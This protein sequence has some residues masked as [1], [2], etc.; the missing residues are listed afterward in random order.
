M[1]SIGTS[2]V[3]LTDF[4]QNVKLVSGTRY[5]IT[6]SSYD[7]SDK[8]ICSYSYIN[9]HYQL[10]CNEVLKKAELVINRNLSFPIR[11]GRKKCN[12]RYYK[13]ECLSCSNIFDSID[14]KL[15]R[16]C[17]KCKITVNFDSEDL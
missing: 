16:I 4:I 1:K 7:I 8:K 12:K 14:P 15:N 5:S 17:N 9:K 13:I 11:Q 10:T 2:L 6:H 3:F